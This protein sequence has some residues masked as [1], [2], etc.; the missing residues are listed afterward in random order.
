VEAPELDVEPL[1]HLLGVFRSPAMPLQHRFC[2]MVIRRP[3]AMWRSGTIDLTQPG[4]QSKQADL[5]KFSRPRAFAVTMFGI[6]SKRV[7]CSTGTSQADMA[8]SSRLPLAAVSSREPIVVISMS[9]ATSR[10]TPDA[11]VVV[12]KGSRA[13]NLTN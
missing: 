13:I 11:S 4:R 1:S 6:N 9:T 10:S 7:G 3:P 2:S 12:I 5:E 8:I